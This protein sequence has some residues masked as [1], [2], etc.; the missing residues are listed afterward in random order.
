ME[1]KCSG[2]IKKFRKKIINTNLIKT[3]NS[4]KKILTAISLMV[5][6]ALLY[7]QG[8]IEIYN[9]GAANG[10]YTNMTISTFAGG[11]GATGTGGLGGGLT[12]TAANGFYYTLLIAAYGGAAPAD[13]PTAGPWSQAVNSSTSLPATATNYLVAGGMRA[14]GGSGGLNINSW[15]AATTNYFMLVGWSANLGSTW[16]EVSTELGAS[17]SAASILAET[18][19]AYSSGNNYFF[20]VSPVAYTFS[21]SPAPGTPTSIFGG[22]GLTAGITLDAVLPQIVPEPST[23]AL[24]GLG[25]LAMLM[26]RRRK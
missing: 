24:A 2:A 9:I 26:F 15:A 25:G 14:A 10:N 22:N 13:T 16:A 18:G 6:T 1:S 5:G 4:M 7:G 23:I 20:G 11:P 8:S 17:W 21:G 19:V 12:V 3:K